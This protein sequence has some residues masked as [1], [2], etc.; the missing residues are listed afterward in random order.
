MK[1]ISK[2]TEFISLQ[3]NDVKNNFNVLKLFDYLVGWLVFQY[4]NYCLDLFFF[5]C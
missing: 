1:F 3:N 5:F 2:C 4:I